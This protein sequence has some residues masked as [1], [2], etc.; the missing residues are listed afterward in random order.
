MI[1][2]IM[3]NGG[4]FKA[5]IIEWHMDSIA[6]VFMFE[7]F[8]GYKIE[9]KIPNFPK[10]M[11]HDFRKLSKKKQLDAVID[12]VRGEINPKE[13]VSLPKNEP[14]IKTDDEIRDILM[15]QWVSSHIMRGEYNPEK[16]DGVPMKQVSSW[17]RHGAYLKPVPIKIGL[18]PKRPGLSKEQ[19]SWAVKR[20]Q[21]G[22]FEREYI[23]QA[24][25]IPERYF[26]QQLLMCGSSLKPQKKTYWARTDEE[27]RDI[28]M[29]NWL[30]CHKRWSDRDICEIYDVPGNVIDSWWVGHYLKPLATKTAGFPSLE[31]SQAQ[32]EWIRSRV[33]VDKFKTYEIAEVMGLP[34]D[35][36][37]KSLGRGG[38]E[39]DILLRIDPTNKD[40]IRDVLME[41]YLVT[42]GMRSQRDVAEKYG[43][44][45]NVLMD[46]S[47][48][49]Y[50]TSEMRVIRG[51]KSVLGLTD[52]QIPW[53]VSRVDS[54]KFTPE[55]ISAVTNVHMDT[56]AI[57]L[58]KHRAQNSIF[59][60]G[61]GHGI[62]IT[63][64]EALDKMD[65]LIDRMFNEG[66]GVTQGN[67]YV[68][69][70]AA[71]WELQQ[72]ADNYLKQD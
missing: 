60:T 17:W 26:E 63:P 19:F 21:D 70:K 36:L 50:L 61:L 7:I 9:F 37:E 40:V 27:I 42:R 54:Q 55:E 48:K 30:V 53:A 41:H 33:S 18:L 14:P 2:V 31:I 69:R 46:W 10:L 72:L 16:E 29:E 4:E 38:L 28:L 64:A 43:I 5:N 45:R 39:G 15:K 1:R 71:A 11:L 23:A 65:I 59:K 57:Q 35:Q 34:L 66:F 58:E 3:P 56:L 52:E 49:S 32:L 67:P 68:D 62:K 6:I 47:T 22:I 44:T 20:I 13:E 12:M 25:G 8:S 24:M 51:T